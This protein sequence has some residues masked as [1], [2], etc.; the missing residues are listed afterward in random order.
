MSTTWA[1][2]LQ[3]LEQLRAQGQDKPARKLQ[4]QLAS[5]IPQA[6]DQI[7]Q[8][9]QRQQ[10]DQAA[11]L[12]DQVLSVNP[13]QSDGLMLRG[14]L[15]LDQLEP[16][17]A[18]PL[19][20]Q[21]LKRDEKNIDA[22]YYLALSQQRD[23]QYAQARRSYARALVADPQLSLRSGDFLDLLQ[24][25]IET[26]PQQWAPRLA[27]FTSYGSCC[28]HDG[29][30]QTLG[31]SATTMLQRPQ[32]VGGVG[33]DSSNYRLVQL[34]NVLQFEKNSPVEWLDRL[35]RDIVLPWLNMA[36]DRKNYE[37]A[38]LLETLAYSS[39]TQ[40]IESEQHF[41][42]SMALLTDPL[43]RAGADY[44]AQLPKPVVAAT[45]N[46]TPK[47]GFLVHNAVHLA[48]VDVM[49]KMLQG[50]QQLP[51]PLIQPIVY[52]FAGESRE[53]VHAL[54]ALD[55]DVIEV[56]RA[57][58][59]SGHL[60]RLD[61][62]RAHIA[63]HRV[64]ALVFMCLSTMMPFAFASRIA[65]TQIWWSVKYHSRAFDEID[66]YV[67]GGVGRYRTID[68][69]RWR[70]SQFG[71]NDWFDAALAP[72]AAQVRQQFS[73]FRLVTGC[74]ARE[75]KM[76]NPDYLDAVCALL[77]E[78][79]DICF[80][81]TGREPLPSIQQHFDAAGVSDRCFFVGWV[82]TRLYAQV[83]D[84]LLDCFPLG[85]GYTAYEAMAA[86]AATVFFASTESQES[87]VPA[88][89]H[90]IDTAG[91]DCADEKAT[92]ARIFEDRTLYHCAADV[93]EYLQLANRL[94][95]DEPLRARSGAANR[96]FIA[97]F[98]ED[99]KK[100][101]DGYAHHFIELIA[102]RAAATGNR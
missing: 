61:Y 69:R 23:N 49:L 5:A 64:D 92:L 84:L 9:R 87:G 48:H 62:I 14:L 28:M 34:L 83:V 100:M 32:L 56:E 42:Q 16:G 58:G 66:G 63:E 1:Q 46:S 44:A 65:P 77:V 40:A 70:A 57:S 18:I 97:A 102:E 36:V 91:D 6:L 30:L 67:T 8:L 24:Y 51:R 85:C 10:F 35:A 47:I 39:Y 27:F 55:C 54:E 79:P 2:A 90:A 86:G 33:D 76:E 53:L 89:V 31:D 20:Q 37:L 71:G 22:Q 81:W 29:E 43:R 21:A 59:A 4:Q 88:L 80:L 95:S 41:R 38:L 98:Y 75:K 19:F 60:A 11:V 94:L 12:C 93:D 13:R 78:N 68:G 74:I 7:V 45:G 17:P 99:Q 96:A 25:M 101:A 50:H 3:Q 73:Q 52:F 15:H 26:P 72:Q 82:N